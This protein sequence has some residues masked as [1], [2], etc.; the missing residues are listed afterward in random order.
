MAK[1]QTGG[2]LGA[3]RQQFQDPARADAEVEEVVHRRRRHAEQPLLHLRFVDIERPDLRPLVRVLAKIGLREGAPAGPDLG[4]AGEIAPADVVVHIAG[5][6]EP[7]RHGA[8]LAFV[9]QSVKYPCA[10]S[11]TH[12]KPR[13]GQDFQMPGDG[14]L[15]HP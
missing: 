9:R 1:V 4:E 3:R 5:A 7:G 2:A 12:H 15:R 13:F 8:G 11:E 14:R 6:D 10:F